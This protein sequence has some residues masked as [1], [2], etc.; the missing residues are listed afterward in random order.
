MNSERRTRRERID[1][2]LGRAGWDVNSRRLVE[3][4]IIESDCVL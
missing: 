3:E 2:Q 4:Y 1:I